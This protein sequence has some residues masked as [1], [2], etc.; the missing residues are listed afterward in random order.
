MSF[1]LLCVPR[2]ISVYSWLFVSSKRATAEKSDITEITECFANNMSARMC[3]VAVQWF[4]AYNIEHSCGN[5]VMVTSPWS[6]SRRKVVSAMWIRDALAG[7]RG[8]VVHENNQ[9]WDTMWLREES[10]KLSRFIL[11][12]H[13]FHMDQA[14]WF[15][16][17]GCVI[18]F[19]LN[20]E[21]WLLKSQ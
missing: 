11:L 21:R 12:E 9:K 4:Q 15:P 2:T 16:F 6:S 1:R 7:T 14:S 5:F 10:Q 8:S 19:G 20:W 18:C 17:Y 13:S 3:I